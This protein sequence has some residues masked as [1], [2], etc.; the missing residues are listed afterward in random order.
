MKYFKDKKHNPFEAENE[1]EEDIVNELNS[2][3]L[4]K[5]ARARGEKLSNEWE[6]RDF[7]SLLNNHKEL[8]ILDTS[9]LRALFLVPVDLTEKGI[10]YRRGNVRDVRRHRAKG[11]TP[12]YRLAGAPID[13]DLAA[14]DPEGALD[15]A[16]F[17]ERKKL[18]AIWEKL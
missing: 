17:R 12:L 3:D 4:D 18:D 11:G 14:K 2:I 5:E 6:R 10:Y 9:E 16:L 1:A 8:R 7:Q 13:V 15:L